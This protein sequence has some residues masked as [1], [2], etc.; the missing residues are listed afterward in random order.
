AFADRIERI[1]HTAYL[2]LERRLRTEAD[3]V[4]FL[5]DD[6]R[7]N[8]FILQNLHAW[9]RLRNREVTLGGLYNPDLT[10]LACDLRKNALIVDPNCVFGSQAFVISF[11]TVKY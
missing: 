10:V 2:A 1:T 11:P 9:E 6:L 7:F 3:Y 8:Q 4:L 5:E